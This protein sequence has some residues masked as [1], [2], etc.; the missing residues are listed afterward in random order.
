[1]QAASRRGETASRPC[2]GARKAFH[3]STL[4]PFLAAIRAAIGVGDGASPVDLL[5][6]GIDCVVRI[7]VQP[8]SS[9]VAR[10][11]GYDDFRLC[12]SPAYLREHGIRASRRSSLPTDWLQLC[13]NRTT[14]PRR[15]FARDGQKIQLSL[16]AC[17]PSY[18]QD[19][20]VCRRSHEFWNREGGELHGATV[21][22]VGTARTGAPLIDG[23]QFPISVMYRKA[24]TSRRRCA[25]SSTG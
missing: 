11:V 18:D 7:G 3:H 10:R 17:W 15:E 5:E 2:P 9:L 21:P 24:A 23:E 1:M 25:S 22:G 4:A 6:E 13:F 19:A 14:S 20:Y 12:A 8:D 16:D